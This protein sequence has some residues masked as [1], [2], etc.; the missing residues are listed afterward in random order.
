[1]KIYLVIALR[2][3]AKAAELAPADDIVIQNKILGLNFRIAE[4]RL[5]DFKDF[6]FRI[7]IKN[8]FP[9]MLLPE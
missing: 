6:L 8:E 5:S 3:G 9:G 4:I 1:M 2:L 7:S